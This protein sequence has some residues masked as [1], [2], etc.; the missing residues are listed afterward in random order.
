MTIFV[1]EIDGCAVAAFY[2]EDNEEAC[3]FIQDE[4]FR[5]D[6]MVLENEGHPLWNGE[7]QIQHREA[8]NEERAA[9]DAARTEAIR[10]GKISASENDFF[11]FLVPVVD[12]IDTIDGVDP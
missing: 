4:T 10:D 3:D 8:L 6:L 1:A 2:A 11:I 12:P 5:G 7:S 9:W